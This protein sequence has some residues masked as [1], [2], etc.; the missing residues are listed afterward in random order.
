MEA[1]AAEFCEESP[2]PPSTHGP[3]SAH[4]PGFPT[5]AGPG[6]ASWLLS[7]RE[8]A[9]CSSKLRLVL[10]QPVWV[11]V[12]AVERYLGESPLA[13][14]YYDV[15]L[16][17]GCV[18]DTWL[19]SPEL[20]PLVHT[21]TL[22]C[23]RWARVTRCSYLY[24]EK[25]LSRGLVRI[26]QLEPGED[27]S[28]ETV[29]E[30]CSRA[31]THNVAA[32]PIQGGRRHYLPLWN[33]ENPYGDIW[34]EN[35]QDQAPKGVEVS[36]VSSLL[37]LEMS[38]R[39]KRPFPPLLVR[40]MH[41]S[42]LRYFGKPDKTFDIPYQAYFEV[43]DQSGM[44]SL[45]L[46]NSLCPEWFK[47]FR[48]G[49]VLFLQQYAVKNSYPN[50][51]LPTP[52]SAQLKRLSKTEISL[53]ARDPSSSFHIVPEKLVKPEWRLPDV[54]YQ[55]C[56]R[57]EL[58]NLPH[59]QVCDVIGLVTY[60]GRCERKRR[61]DSE[62]FWLYRWVQ[63]IDGTTDQPFVLEIFATSQ[64]EIFE[65]IHPM[66]YLVCTQMRVVREFPG[67]P[68]SLYLT[69]S[70]ESQVFISGHHKGQ[71]YIVDNK[72]KSFI[73][74]TKTQN[75]AEILKK[76]VIGG[77]HRYPL[78]PATFLKYCKDNKVES[79]LTTFSELK[80]TIGNLHYRESKRVAIQGMIA[81]L[82]FVDLNSVTEDASEKEADQ[83][84][85]LTSVQ[86]VS[87]SQEY[88]ENTRPFLKDHV[89][90]TEPPMEDSP[91]LYVQQNRSR[92]ISPIKRRKRLN[93]PEE[94]RL[95]IPENLS[96]LHEASH[97][98]ET[99]SNEESFG[100]N[101]AVVDSEI[102]ECPRDSWESDL[103]SEV[104][105][106]IEEHLHYGTLFPESIPRKFDY[107]QKEFLI[108]QFNLQAAKISTKAKR[109]SKEIHQFTSANSLGHFELTI[110]GINHS[111]A[112]DVVY[113]PA[114]YPDE[115]HVLDINSVI[116]NPLIPQGASTTECETLERTD[117][118]R[119][120]VKGELMKIVSALD[121][122]NTI[123]ILDICHLGDNKVEVSLNRVYNP[124]TASE[125]EPAVYN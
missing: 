117:H 67:D 105:D 70:N 55:F 74:W 72:V 64:P 102:T 41:K 35:S 46:W 81:A 44:M 108:Q 37:H 22:R 56:T 87:A 73:D 25:R 109:S 120:A 121:K 4:G 112:I 91:E 49:S 100:A 122:L 118:R 45:V 89:P 36:K 98:V 19:L 53:N 48:V 16:S 90:Q 93:Q 50:R 76:T 75:E 63:M 29:T 5:L 39:S 26:D 31:L 62:D 97:N 96:L 60:V 27:L 24:Q 107:F 65:C 95:V 18:R 2:G 86:E 66:S 111:I 69:T 13:A 99:T 28:A 84:V 113:L 20:T 88:E 114:L 11:A 123:C 94:N 8:A 17:D 34:K 10:Q 85:E 79:I 115:P 33:N 78:T 47:T 77:Y 12:M 68:C 21:N 3:P 7:T 125:T 52:G 101:E 43:A 82:H 57:L 124:V 32:Q 119:S 104:K 38:W 30:L 71:P 14:Y 15:T 80:K 59:N 61:D 1:Q 92:K 6:A 106:T 103:W 83:G 9:R 42:R 23:G 58:N 51:T 116:G 54:K 40:I 110:L